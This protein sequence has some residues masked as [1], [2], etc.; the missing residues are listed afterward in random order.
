MNRTYIYINDIWICLTQLTKSFVLLSMDSYPLNKCMSGGL[1]TSKQW[2]LDTTYQHTVFS[3]LNQ[4]INYCSPLRISMPPQQP[5]SLYQ[6]NTICQ[7]YCNRA[8]KINFKLLLWIELL[9][10]TC[11]GVNHNFD[12]EV[13]YSWGKVR[14]TKSSIPHNLDF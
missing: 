10:T 5:Y 11:R 2:Q 14:H 3:T 4:D 6:I 13:L 7:N 12:C 1:S 8:Y 9:L